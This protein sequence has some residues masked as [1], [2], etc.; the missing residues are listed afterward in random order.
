MSFKLPNENVQ[1]SLN[2]FRAAA[3]LNVKKLLVIGSINAFI[4]KNDLLISDVYNHN[5]KIILQ[6]G[7]PPI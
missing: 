6:Y 5:I 4:N 2:I 7:I 3:K 1:I